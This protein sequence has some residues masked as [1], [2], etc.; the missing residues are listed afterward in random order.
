MGDSGD[1]LL[2][3][4]CGDVRNGERMVRCWGSDEGSAAISLVL[5]VRS[6][7]PGRFFDSAVFPV[8]EASLIAD[9][10]VVGL[11]RCVGP[12]RSMSVEKRTRGAFSVDNRDI[13]GREKPSKA[14]D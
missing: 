5:M 6:G 8:C 13:E 7:V 9:V 4:D 2:L 14:E 3:G 10:A 11:D 1:C 12:W